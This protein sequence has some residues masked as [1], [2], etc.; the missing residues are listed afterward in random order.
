M[1]KIVSVLLCAALMAGLCA[2]GQKPVQTDPVKTVKSAEQL[3]HYGSYSDI[4]AALKKAREQDASG[5]YSGR[6]GVFNAAAATGTAADKT[7]ATGAETSASAGTQNVAAAPDYSATNVQVAGVDEGDIVKTDGKNIYAIKDRELLIYQPDGAST[8][9]L[10]R[11]TL[12]GEND[13]KY[14]ME[15]YISGD[16]LAVVMSE[17][18]YYVMNDTAASGKA[19]SSAAMIAPGGYGTNKVTVALYDVS[20]PAAPKALATFGQDGS[21]LTSRLYDGKLYLV[22][23]H[24]GTG[25]LVEGQPK[26]FAPC[27]YLNGT[28][29]AIPAADIV[30]VP[31]PADNGYAVICVFDLQSG[32]AAGTLSVLGGGSTLYMNTEKLYLADTEYNDTSSAARTES[33]YTVVDHSCSNTTT[34]TAVTLSTLTADACGSVPGT[35]LNSYSMDAYD[36]HLRLAATN[37]AYSYSVYTDKSMG[38]EN[39]KYPDDQQQQTN[40]LYV[41]DSGL[42]IVGRAENLAAGETIYSAR[43]DGPVAYLCTYEQTDPLF[44]FDLSD[45]ANPVKLGEMK[46]TGF[47]D[48]LHVWADGR[49]FGLG[50]AAT[51]QGQVTG[52]KMVMFDV[53]DK[54]NVSVKATLDLGDT[55]SEA[56]ND[57]N[58]ILVSP[59][60]NL[61]GFATNSGYTFYSYSDDA[62]FTKLA[63]VAGGDWDY[64]MRG[65]YIG[66]FLYIVSQSGVTVVELAS[67][68]TVATV[69]V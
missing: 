68:T 24:Y 46:I 51:E 42:N 66:D 29:T 13:G 59:D 39:Y 4:Y 44:A 64:N 7:A 25:D 56:L 67:Y 50:Q 8:K 69:A 17:Y 35:L 1:K 30:S 27:T 31:S 15:L 45:P 57:P 34:L 37:N 23:N 38:F 52:M 19:V 3:V 22:T 54:T 10:S 49:L 2:C 9:L 36:G 33:V 12:S 18:T 14:P 5:G 47:S 62:G 26:T 32:T 58:A 11:V 53:S 28:A 41:L 40:A 21:L 63:S 6:P 20:D 48:Y 65:L 16:R 55:Y 43:F 60:K 61:I